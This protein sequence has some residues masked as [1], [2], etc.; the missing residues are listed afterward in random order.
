MKKVEDGWEACLRERECKM[1]QARWSREV[2]E[3]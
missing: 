1:G 2:N 3:A